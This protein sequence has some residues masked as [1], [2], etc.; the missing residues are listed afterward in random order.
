MVE[1]QIS[2]ES[3]ED[4]HWLRTWGYISDTQYDRMG[5]LINNGFVTHKKHMNGGRYL[6]LGTTIIQDNELCLSRMS[7]DEW[8]NLKFKIKNPMCCSPLPPMPIYSCSAEIQ[9]MEY[10]NGNLYLRGVLV[11]VF[12]SQNGDRVTLKYVGDNKYMQ[13]HKITINL[14]NS[15]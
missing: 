1:A 4:I 10:I 11:Y 6:M 12:E 2:K 13:G 9:P 14:I 8:N 5:W 3:L 7:D 15:E